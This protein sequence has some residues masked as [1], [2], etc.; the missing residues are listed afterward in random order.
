M[1]TDLSKIADF[2]VAPFSIE[3]KNTLPENP[4]SDTKSGL[5]QRVL[6]LPD[7]GGQ[8]LFFRDFEINELPLDATLHIGALGC[9]DIYCNGQRVGV[10]EDGKTVYNEM[11]PGSLS[12]GKR[13]MFD[14][15]SL[16]PYLKEGKNRLLVTVTSGWYKVRIAMVHFRL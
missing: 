3:V 5:A 8:L 16:R 12:Y 4:W 9:Y 15:Y 6:D 2:I 11:K 1:F 13:T 7:A 10:C 14:S